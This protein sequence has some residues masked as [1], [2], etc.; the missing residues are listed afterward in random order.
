M[1]F[2]QALLAGKKPVDR[3]IATGIP[4]KAP[5]R[6]A[7]AEVLA[8]FQKGSQLDAR[9]NSVCKVLAEAMDSFGFE[10]RKFEPFSKLT[11]TAPNIAQSLCSVSLYDP[12]Q[13]R[14][15]S[16]WTSLYVW[17]TGPDTGKFQLRC[18]V[19]QQCN[20]QERERDPLTHA[21]VFV[22][23][24]FFD[25][26]VPLSLGGASSANDMT[27]VALRAIDHKLA[28]VAEIAKGFAESMSAESTP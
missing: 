11:P 17:V 9:L 13:Q 23:K 22:D 26:G 24:Y 2:H 18:Q 21:I 14:E 16:V 5:G 10:Q 7:E 6:I 20:A 1:K 25:S 15:F 12:C 28:D 4:L 8:A 3:A 27:A 19:I